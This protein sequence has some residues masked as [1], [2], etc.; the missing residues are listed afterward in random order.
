M[1]KVAVTQHEPAWLDLTASIDKTCRLIEEAANNESK[2]IVF[3]EVWIPGYPAWI[4]A[5][6]VDPPLATQY[7]KSSLS[8]DSPEMSKICSAAK[9]ANIAVV[10]GFSENEHNSLYLAQCTISASG[11]IVMKRRKM[12]PSHMERT[13]FGDGNGPSLNNVVELDGVGKVGALS[14]WEH[15][16]PLLKYHTISLREEIHVSAWPPLIPFEEGSQGLYG[17]SA[18][19]GATLSQAYAMESSAF[20]LHC[21]SIFTSSGVRAHQTEG[22]PI[23][24]LVGGGHSAVYGPDGRRLTKPIPPDQEGFVYA[25]LPMDML[26]GIKHFFDPVGHYSRPDMLWLGVDTREKKHVR[27]HGDGD[28]VSETK[29]APVLSTYTNGVKKDE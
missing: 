24:G 15:M 8:Y 25:E 21:T 11:E 20:V 3:P 23:T 6:P 10:L 2:L 17:M 27:G 22:N 14:C 1:V 12:K 7:I 29:Q 19:G 18:D 26:L 4:W 13:V 16:H 9:N 28:N 5:R